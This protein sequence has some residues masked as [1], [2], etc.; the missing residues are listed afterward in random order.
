VHGTV[1]IP[2]DVG[3]FSPA[4]RPGAAGPGTGRRL[5]IGMNG[6][7]S[8]PRKNTALAIAAFRLVA[9]ERADVDL[10]VR[11][12]LGRAEFLERSGAQDLAD[13]IDIGPEVPDSTFPD[14]YR[15]LDVFAITSWQEGLCVTGT[16]AMACGTTVVSTRCGGPEDYVWDRQTGRLSGF[17]PGDFASRLLEA[18]DDA[19]GPRHLASAGV[20]YIRQRFDQANFERDFMGHFTRTFG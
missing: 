6:R 19:T 2:V 5:R 12:D 8:D 14:Y 17:N 18:L 20:D 4:G 9:R 15:S 13:R 11:G 10:V 7:L 16:E 1:L 3:R